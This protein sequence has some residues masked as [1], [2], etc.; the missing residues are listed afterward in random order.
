MTYS[1]LSGVEFN[2]AY[3][4]AIA[5]NMDATF[6]LD[7]ATKKGIGEGM[8]YRYV[9]KQDSFGQ[10]YAHHLREK[11]EYRENR[12]EQLDRKPDRW[13]VDFQHEEYR[14]SSF[15]AKTRLRALSD[16]QYFKDFGVSYE[17]RAS[18]QLNSFL[19]LTKNWE[20]S[21][22][23]GEARHTVDLR[24]SDPT[25]LQNYPVIN[26][27]GLRKQLLGFPALLQF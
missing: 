15:F 5:K 13:Q 18:E 14:D 12:T 20:S 10:F 17:D 4:W 23:F 6:F 21:S 19:S 8:E 9:R 16:R 3:Y 27:T 7:L 22:L 26:F 11:E 24:Q 25:T 2:T 1:N